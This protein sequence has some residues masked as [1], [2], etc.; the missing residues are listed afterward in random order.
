MWP[1][2][3][4]NRTNFYED[5]CS[6]RA[7]SYISIQ[8]RVQSSLLPI[9]FTI[10]GTEGPGRWSWWSS[11]GPP[12]Q[13]CQRLHKCR[14]HQDGV[15]DGWRD[16]GGRAG[17]GSGSGPGPR[18]D[19]HEQRMGVPQ[20]D[21]EHRGRRHSVRTTAA[22][23]LKQRPTPSPTVHRAAVQP[24]GREEIG[25]QNGLLRSRVRQF[26]HCGRDFTHL[27]L[28][29]QRYIILRLDKTLPGA[30]ARP[31]PCWTELTEFSSKLLLPA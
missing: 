8:W 23:Q 28:G 13:H 4:Q 1:C 9:A 31:H 21:E 5:L 6:T 19:Q 30:G 3:L 16:A 22:V 15:W 2:C 27:I 17:N 29:Q 24:A 12:G 10:V 20:H 14:H 26:L 25:L 18:P 7:S 11:D